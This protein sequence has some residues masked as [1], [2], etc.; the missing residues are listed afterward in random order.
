M[1]STKEKQ[2]E[3]PVKKIQK[4]LALAA[5]DPESEESKS[6]AAMAAKLMAKYE[7]SCF[8][9][10]E[11]NEKTKFV[12]ERFEA[13]IESDVKWQMLLATGI[14]DTFDCVVA[15]FDRRD[16][17]HWIFFGAES[18]IELCSWYFKFLRTKIGK[19][20]SDLYKDKQKKA[21]YC[22]GAVLSV[23]QTLERLFVVKQQ[24]LD[25]TTKDLV[26]HRKDQILDHISNRF[27]AFR[28]ESF[29]VDHTTH[30]EAFRN[31]LRDGRNVP[32]QKTIT[33]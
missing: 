32:L 18:S 7:I 30:Q 13:T 2:E 23:S 20:G 12:E 8:E 31:G 4:L 27:G 15:R 9:L 17:K 5:R 19:M 10:K 29:N 28:E 3:K 1:N 21:K 11:T 16:G 26:I 33:N 25:K 24:H 14:A 22:L 6:A